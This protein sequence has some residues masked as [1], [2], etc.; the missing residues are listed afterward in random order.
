MLLT[1]TGGWD[2]SNSRSFLYSFFCLCFSCCCWLGRGVNEVSILYFLRVCVVRPQL[3][4]TLSSQYY[5]RHLLNSSP[6]TTGLSGNL[7]SG[8]TQP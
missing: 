3:Y 5:P 2:C 8:Y 1:W 7:I 4:Y 6:R